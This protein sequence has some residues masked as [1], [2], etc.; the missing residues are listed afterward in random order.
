MRTILNFIVRLL[1]LLDKYLLLVLDDILDIV[2][3]V[4]SVGIKVSLF[5]ILYK[6]AGSDFVD[7]ILSTLGG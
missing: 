3:N 7:R 1:R 4:V 2:R 6:I 5:V